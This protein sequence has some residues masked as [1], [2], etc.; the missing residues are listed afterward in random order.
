MYWELVDSGLAETASLGH[1]EYLGVGMYY[2]FLVCE[3]DEVEENLA[4][5]HAIYQKVES[6]GI[7]E[8]E[9]RQAQNKVKARIVLGSE[10]PQNR[11]SNVGDN[12]LQ[13]REYRTL[14]EELRLLDDV[15]VDD[16]HAVLKKFPLSRYTAI[17]V[18][19]RERVNRPG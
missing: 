12:W 16:L 19:P 6:E 1:Y 3:P 10:R 5:L 18:G 14:A 11:L 8:D 9:L 7:T 13:R 15:T 17:A 4:R 2:T